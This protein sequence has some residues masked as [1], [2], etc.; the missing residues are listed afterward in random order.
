[1]EEN[2]KLFIRGRVSLGDEP[3]GKLICERIIPFSQ[4]PKELWIQFP[5]KDAYLAAERE[6][7]EILKPAEGNDQVIIYLRQEKAKK[8]LPPGWRVQAD[9]QL[10]AKLSEL[11]GEKNVKVV[12]KTIEKIGKMN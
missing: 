10:L 3:A 7:L 4:I 6:L 5:D 12:E 11:Y 1:M 8:I 9:R 2:A